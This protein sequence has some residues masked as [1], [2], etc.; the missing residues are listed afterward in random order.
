[1]LAFKRQKKA[2]AIEKDL[3]LINH[4]MTT[5]EVVSKR[6]I[7]KESWSL[8]CQTRLFEETV[9]LH[10]EKFFKRVFRVTE[11]SSH[12]I[13]RNAVSCSPQRATPR[14]RAFGTADSNDW[15]TTNPANTAALSADNIPNHTD[16]AYK[17][18]AV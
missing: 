10:G 9:P 4:L 6:S 5:M 8:S 16:V 7:D 18:S 11:W 14:R 3:L 12:K 1:M 17:T 13:M 2:D 15:T